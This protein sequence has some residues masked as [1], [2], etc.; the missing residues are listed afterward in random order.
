M[1]QA[2]LIESE[3]ENEIVMK[4]EIRSIWSDQRG[5]DE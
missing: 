5:K 1:N 4:N 3:G 2:Q